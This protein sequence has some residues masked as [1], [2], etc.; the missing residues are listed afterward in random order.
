[1][2]S[3]GGGNFAL[4]AVGSGNKLTEL[5]KLDN[6]EAFTISTAAYGDRGALV[7]VGDN[8]YSTTNQ[9]IDIDANSTAQQFAIVKN[10]DQYYLF[11]ISAQKF[12]NKGTGSNAV[13]STIGEPVSLEYND[14]NFWKIFFGD[15]RLNF[16]DGGG[17]SIN[18]YGTYLDSHTG[19]NDSGNKFDIVSVGNASAS[20]SAALELLNTKDVTYNVYFGSEQKGTAT[21]K[22]TIGRA[23]VLPD[24]LKKDFAV[25]TYNVETVSEETTVI[26]ATYAGF[27]GPFEVST[28]FNDATWYFLK[29]RGKYT[30]WDETAEQSNCV[31]DKVTDD[32][33][34][35]A[36]IGNPYDGFKVYNKST[37]AD[38]TLQV[39]DNNNNTVAKLVTDEGTTGN[40]VW[41]ILDRGDGQFMLYTGSN[42][43][44]EQGKLALWNSAYDSGSYFTAE[45]VPTSEL[46]TVTYNI[47]FNN[48]TVATA[49]VQQY[50][51]EAPELPGSLN[52]TGLCNYDV[53]TTPIT[54]N[55]SYDVTATWV[56]P[57]QFSSNYANANW[58]N[59]TIRST[60]YVNAAGDA[61]YSNVENAS[62]ALRATDEYQWAFL[63]NPYAV[64]IINKAGGASKSLKLVGSNF[65]LS[66]GQNGLTIAKSGDD[67]FAVV[68]RNADGSVQTTL[69]DNGGK[70]GTWGGDHI[71]DGGSQLRI[72]D[73]PEPDY[74]AAVTTDIK[75][76]MDI[77]GQLFG[78]KEDV[79]TTNKSTYEAALTTCNK[80][81]YNALKA[82][83]DN[84]ENLVYPET[85]YYR[86]ESKSKP[87]YWLQWE[88]PAD[89][90]TN[91]TGV[92]FVQNGNTSASSVVR[93]EKKDGSLNEYAI[94][95][96]GKYLDAPDM[97]GGST[98]TWKGR[99]S[100]QNDTPHYYT[101][102]VKTPGQV[103]FRGA[104]TG[105]QNDYSYAQCAD[106]QSNCFVTWSYEAKSEMSIVPVADIDITLNA[107]GDE[108]TYATLYVPFGVTL[109]DGVDAYVVSSTEDDSH[110]TT[111]KIGKNIPA[112]TPV[113]LRGTATSI[114]ATIEDVDPI[115]TNLLKGTYTERTLGENDVVLGNSTTKGIGFYKSS[116]ATLGAN[117]AYLNLSG[118]PVKGFVLDFDDDATG[119]EKTLSNSPLKSENIYNL[120][121]QR[122]QKMQKGLYIVNGKKVLVK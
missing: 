44:N 70:L 63:G 62:D 61:P 91:N 5:S 110:A 8:A 92:K 108:H 84:V 29:I 89:Y 94:K 109:P 10:N 105:D 12:V 117:K 93:F 53:P 88:E 69:N 31:S 68:V 56:G 14:G 121:G 81:T 95:I 87:G 99:T 17:M 122:I 102:E 28:S 26:N 18:Y 78:I 111:E 39:A 46:T 54:A 34:Q 97:T 86:V 42:Y 24:N 72:V 75:P 45:A 115:G 11:S 76:W 101:F 38:M 83:V 37:G 4:A 100:T 16:G 116:A 58:K 85:G 51:G 119:I 50:T 71:S 96:Q 15:Y 32:N 79:Y 36:F 25:Y 104:T 59:M 65:V 67:A 20:V 55:A 7:V 1:M 35:W 80:T 48:E 60:K 103:T 19:E 73:V 3:L 106:G 57:F 40:N 43:I 114:T 30:A 33:G 77:H 82:I 52:L 64:V 13:L 49:T 107:G 41:Q 98:N 2:R 9:N 66:D 6:T 118:S 113:I 27:V 74:A 112:A 21:A 90:S 23:P 120:A 22:A 47:K